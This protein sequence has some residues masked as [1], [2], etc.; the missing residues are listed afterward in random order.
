[1]PLDSDSVGADS[2]PGP[3]AFPR[4]AADAGVY[5]GKRLALPVYVDAGLL[6]YRK[7]LLARYGYPSPPGTWDE[8]MDMA[9]RIQEKE[10]AADPDFQGY[11][12]QGAQYEGLVC[13]FL[14]VAVS[15]GG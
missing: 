15:A 3:D 12:W 6:Y 11:V 9:R 4:A 1:F 10:R 14:E 7:D 8:M 2:L 13:N 5:D